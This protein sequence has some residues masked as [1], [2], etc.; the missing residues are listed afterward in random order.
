[1]AKDQHLNTHQRQSHFE[2]VIKQN[3]NQSNQQNR[4]TIRFGSSQH[5]NYNFVW[6]TN[7]TSR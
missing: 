1:M 6:K 4:T 2:Q 7:T 3:P 5:S